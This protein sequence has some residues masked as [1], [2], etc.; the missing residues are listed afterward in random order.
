MADFALDTLQHPF[1]PLLDI[2]GEHV[3]NFQF[4]L[5]FFTEFIDKHFSLAGFAMLREYSRFRAKPRPV[6]RSLPVDQSLAGKLI[7][8]ASA[9]ALRDIGPAAMAVLAAYGLATAP[10]HFAPTPDDAV[11]T[12]DRLGYPVVLKAVARDLSHKSDVGGV[13]LNLAGA[14]A[15]RRAFRAIE[16]SLRLRLPQA[17]VT[18]VVVQH[19]LSGGHEFI[20]GAKRDPHF[21]PVVMFG[22]G[23]IYA[24]VFADVAF[25]LAPLMSEE[26]EELIW[27]VKA[28]RILKGLRGQP[29]ADVPALAE[30]IVRL[31][32]LIGDWEEIKE[33]DV[34]PI[35]VFAAGEGAIAV[36]ARIV[37]G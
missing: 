3:R 29:P 20:L 27:D 16:N 26:A 31:G 2:V 6:P 36:D 14:D 37:L 5:D 32:Q 23:G 33:I 30:A 28:S 34:N 1:R 12:A 17:P 8:D 25:R 18:G 4:A 24:E 10:L 7:A 35:K 13:A 21:G 19:M 9:E 22:L 11:A 15:V